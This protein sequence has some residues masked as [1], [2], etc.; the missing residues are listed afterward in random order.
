MAKSY[1]VMPENI[2]MQKEGKP[3]GFNNNATVDGE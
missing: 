3:N 2:M 1:F